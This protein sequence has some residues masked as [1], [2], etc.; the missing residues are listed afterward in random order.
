MKGGNTPLAPAV[1]IVR[2]ADVAAAP[3]YE[4]LTRRVLAYNDRLMIVE[5]VMAAG[6]VF[7][8][9]S[10]P[11]EQLAYLMSGYIRVRC[12]DQTFDASAGDSFVIPG[13]M[14]H[15]VQAIER[16]VAL[17]VFTP[18]REDYEATLPDRPSGEDAHTA[19]RSDT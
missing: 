17:D 1:M 18:C 9:H 10:H 7:P 3:A 5:H 19:A 11:H 16:S 6:S 12:G 2:G 4:G 15:E 14:E 8:R 13:G